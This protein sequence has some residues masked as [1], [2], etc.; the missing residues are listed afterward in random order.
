[1]CVCVC[2]CYL[3]VVL[4]VELGGSLL[5]QTA[6]AI[7]QWGEHS[8]GN[9]DV[10][11]LHKNRIIYNLFSHVTQVIIE[12]RKILHGCFSG[13]TVQGYLECCSSIEASC[14]QLASLDG[15]RCQLPFALQNVSNGINV[16]H[17]GLLFIIHWNLSSPREWYTREFSKEEQTILNLNVIPF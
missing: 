1:M 12:Q 16:G 11:T 7:L 10:V 13:S 8:C 17:V 9:V 6:G 2:V 4:P 15:N 5:W 14:Q 3:D